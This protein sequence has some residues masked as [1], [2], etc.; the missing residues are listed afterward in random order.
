[1]GE[2]IYDKNARISLVILIIIIILYIS[3]GLFFKTHFFFRTSVD[4]IDISLKTVDEAK[5]VIFDKVKDFKLDIKGRDDISDEII[6]TDIELEYEGNKKIDELKE[7]QKPFMWMSALIEK[8]DYNDIKLFLYNISMLENKIDNLKFIT[9]SN[10][11]EPKNPEFQYTDGKYIVLEEVKGNKINRERLLSVI[12]TAIEN[13]NKEID[14]DESECYEKPKYTINSS[15]VN[16]AKEIMDKYVSS[17]I[18]YTF[19]ENMETVDGALIN[20]WIDVSEDMKPKIDEKKVKEYI[21]TL[22][23]KYNTVGKE[24]KFESSIGKT[25]IVK[26]GYYGWKINSKEEVKALI[27][28]LEHGQ[29]ILKEPIYSQK[30]VSRS[31]DDIGYTYVEVNITRQHLWFYKDGKVIVQGD[32]VTGSQ[33]KN[34]PTYLGVYGLNYKQKDATLKGEGYSSKVSYWMPFNGNIGLHDASWRSSF[35]GN[36]YKVNGT[37][38]CINMPKY[39][40]KSI[41][42][43]IDINTPII[44]YSED[45]KSS[46]D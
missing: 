12:K 1:M 31:D 20:K 39:L 15:E 34:T 33:S 38:G 43:N 46:N 17:K 28:N 8:N 5:A 14:L 42:E 41:Y 30:G 32:I 45:T 6:S 18:V 7:S 29:N 10:I 25:V 16:E 27:D 22:S 36:I 23:K 3:G 19:D 21:N 24:R 26:G 4:G 37:H 2:L 9:N 13:G 11:I 40:A 35:G 44:C